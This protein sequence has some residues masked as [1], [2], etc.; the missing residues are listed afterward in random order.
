ME[1]K[2]IQQVTVEERIRPVLEAYHANVELV[3]VTADGF[4]K[5]KITGNYIS[6]HD[7]EK[8]ILEMVE[9]AF[10]EIICSDIKGVIVV[11]KMKRKINNIV[12]FLRSDIR[13][14]CRYAIA[15]K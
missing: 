2:Q 9:A 5:V 4:L 11:G 8:N 15:I 6:C 13:K 10:R 14:R 1:I 12:S 7:A 3:R